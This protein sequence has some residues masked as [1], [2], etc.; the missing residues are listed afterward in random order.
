[1]TVYFL[2]YALILCT[3]GLVSRT[4]KTPEQ[5][6]KRAAFY[7]TALVV[8]V[9][10][11]RHPSMG[12]D[13]G[14]G[15]SIGYLTSFQSISEYSW[16]ELFALG[17]WQNYEWGYIVFNK[18]LGYISTNYQCLLI[19]CAIAS[20][21]PVGIMIG[22]CSRDPVLAI[23]VFLGLPCITVPFSALRQGIAVGLCCLS[24][25]LIREKKPVKFIL[26]IVF[27]TLF[28][29]SA[30]IFLV[31]YPLY[32]LKLSRSARLLSIPV[33]PVIYLA[34][35]PLFAVGSKLFKHNAVAAQ[36]SAVTLLLVFTLV[37]AFCAVFLHDD[38]DGGF[39]NLFYVACVIQCFAG[40]YSLAMRVGFYFMPALVIALPNIIANMKRP[41]N[42]KIS[43]L[44]VMAAFVAYGLYALYTYGSDWPMTYPYHFF[45]NK[46]V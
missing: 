24:F 37:Y 4:G 5:R 9:V 16:G 14:Y 42:R 17:E 20:I 38:E 31:A 43:R 32:H 18:L 27:A 12:I 45:W 29:Y 13:L 23:L 25:P 7:V 3:T 2:M 11:L 19:A 36:G 34:R 21:V 44:C 28:H 6:K 1:M 33:L 15:S 8:L 41:E 46:I 10:A 35:Y 22:K 26:L 30:F 40:V 39:L